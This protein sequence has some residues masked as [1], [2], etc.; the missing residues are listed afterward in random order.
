MFIP[1]TA[2]TGAWIPKGKE[3]K[4]LATPVAEAGDISVAVAVNQLNE[5][6]AAPVRE[7]CMAWM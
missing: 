1:E 6:V 3:R 7:R 4:N 2:V 5:T